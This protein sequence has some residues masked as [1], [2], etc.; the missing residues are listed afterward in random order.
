MGKSKGKGKEKELDAGYTE[1]KHVSVKPKEVKYKLKT[2]DSSGNDV[3]YPE[4][5]NNIAKATADA[6]KSVDQLVTTV[7]AYSAKQKEIRREFCEGK[8]WDEQEL[9]LKKK[10]KMEQIMRPIINKSIDDA[11]TKI[12]KVTNRVA[13]PEFRDY[14]SDLEK[15]NE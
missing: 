5:S 2:T 3:Y 9:V 13:N 10:E 14:N 7:N 4:V 1:D 15:K 8:T 12:N 11:E 6:S